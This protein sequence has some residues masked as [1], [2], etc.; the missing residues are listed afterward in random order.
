MNNYYDDVLE[1]F[2][3]TALGVSRVTIDMIYDELYTADRANV[4]LEHVKS[5]L[6]ILCTL[7]ETE[8]LKPTQTPAKLLERPIL[9][10]RYASG[11]V[12]L[13]SAEV[14][15]AIVDRRPLENLFRDRVR[16]LDFTLVEIVRLEPLL[17]W[18]N[19][20][21]RYLSKAV[22][23]NSVVDPELTWLVSDPVRDI[24]RKAHA[25]TR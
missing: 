3:V 17:S 7:L 23:H 5:S 6:G 15:F 10:V 9:P 21:D 1:D 22:R 11:D 25:L 18:M 14:E 20:G 19:L 16:L 2:F 4:T 8:K 24:K 12:R 13:V